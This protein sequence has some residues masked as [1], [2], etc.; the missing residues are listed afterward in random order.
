MK[1]NDIKRYI[2]DNELK[3]YKKISNWKL[4]NFTKTRCNFCKNEKTISYR[5][6]TYLGFYNICSDCYDIIEKC[7]KEYVKE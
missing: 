6:P 7:E 1:L 2:S 4:K 5:H 3:K